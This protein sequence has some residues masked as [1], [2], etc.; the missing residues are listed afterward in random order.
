MQAYV[1]REFAPSVATAR[2]ARAYLEK[3]VAQFGLDR[4]F[5]S[6]Q[7]EGALRGVIAV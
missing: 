2:Q 4:R 7:I 3:L 5:A 1:A 6:A